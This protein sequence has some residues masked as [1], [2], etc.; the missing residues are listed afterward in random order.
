MDLSR[1]RHLSWRVV[2]VAIFVFLAALWVTPVIA[3][4]VG[5]V[6]LST[7][8]RPYLVIGT[9]VVLDAIIPVFPSESL[10]TTASNLAAQPG[11]DI[12]LWRL[13]LAGSLGAIIG[14]SLLYWL[15]RTVQRPA[16][17]DRVDAAMANDKVARTMEV[18]G[19]RAPL[20][21][22]FGRFVPG[23][24]FMVGATMGLTRF[25][26]PRFLLWDAIGGTLWAVYT[27]VFCYLIASVINDMPVVSI[28]VS[29][30]V[31]TGMLA[32]LYIPLKR[33]WEE[34]EGA[35]AASNEVVPVEDLP[36]GNSATS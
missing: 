19:A 5:N 17:E 36:V 34:S 10:L 14:D 11:S 32:V 13:I 7:L 23:V 22:V 4:W 35:V 20:L 30:V 1:P 27:C 31:T 26:Y 12:E 33:S 16:M 2:V 21:I 24:R 3:S 25:P 9:F 8:S 6:D 28:A 15:A 18:L 29:V